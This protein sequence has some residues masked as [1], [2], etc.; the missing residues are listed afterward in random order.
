MALSDSDIAAQTR[1]IAAEHAGR[2]GPLL[3]ILHAVQEA[4]GHIPEAARPEIAQALN[5]SAAELHGVVSFYSDFRTAPGGRR[6]LRLCA[7]EACQAMGGAALSARVLAALGLNGFGTTADGA[8]TVE[9]AYCL[10]L[11]ACAPAAMLDGR[12]LGRVTEDG[13][14]AALKEAAPC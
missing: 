6:R 13:L 8:L 7:A 11:C 1:A 4:F 10:G 2:E 9:P 12:P 3:P 5:I 14:A